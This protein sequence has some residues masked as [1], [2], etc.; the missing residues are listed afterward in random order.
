MSTDH[1]HFLNK[2]R[3]IPNAGPRWQYRCDRNDFSRWLRA[4]RASSR[5]DY[6]FDGECLILCLCY[7]RKE[8]QARGPG[9]NEFLISARVIP[10]LH[11]RMACRILWSQLHV[12]GWRRE[13][14]RCV[15]MLRAQ[16]RQAVKSK[17]DIDNAKA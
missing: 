11:L 10:A 7:H 9:L 15:R 13:T 5:L 4:N 17:T 2:V 3:G 6:Y 12:I 1:T 14:A 16:M 8:R